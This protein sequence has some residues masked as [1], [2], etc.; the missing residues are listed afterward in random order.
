MIKYNLYGYI[1]GEIQMTQRE[2]EI[3]ILI[4]KNKNNLK[5]FVIKQFIINNL[6]FL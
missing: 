1:V 6:I 2:R 4:I 3:F 5:N